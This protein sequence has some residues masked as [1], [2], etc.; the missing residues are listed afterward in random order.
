VVKDPLALGNKAYA[1]PKVRLVYKEEPEFAVVSV[2][3]GLRESRDLK[4][5]QALLE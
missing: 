3:A 4:V 5:R 1:V 2:S